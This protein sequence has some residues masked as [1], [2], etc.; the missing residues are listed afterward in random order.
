MDFITSKF[1]VTKECCSFSH[2]L[3]LAL[4]VASLKHEHSN[5]RQI[6]QDLQF[7]RSS[8]NRRFFARTSTLSG[9][10]SPSR[11]KT[12]SPTL[13]RGTSAASAI[14]ETPQRPSQPDKGRVSSGGPPAFTE[15]TSNL[16]LDAAVSSKTNTSQRRATRPVTTGQRLQSDVSSASQYDDDIRRRSSLGNMVS[17][18][19][20]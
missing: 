7:R 1:I 9:G 3:S 11:T 18:W 10:N 8:G 17:L 5:T 16:F 13:R 4:R 15:A 6:S 20:F 14:P 2:I 12:V 19:S